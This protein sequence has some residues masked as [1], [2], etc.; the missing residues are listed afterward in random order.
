MLSHDGEV[1]SR[2]SAGAPRCALPGVVDYPPVYGMI[3]NS[4]TGTGNSGKSVFTID[5][6][7]G[8]ASAGR[9]ADVRPIDPYIIKKRRSSAFQRGIAHGQQTSFTVTLTPGVRENGCPNS[10]CTH[11]PVQYSTENQYITRTVLCSCPPFTA[12][13]FFIL[14][15][16]NHTS[17]ESARS[18]HYNGVWYVFSRAHSAPISSCTVHSQMTVTRGV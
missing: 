15:L 5:C 14:T 11:I 8:T 9:A 2:P 10:T 18:Q 1:S 4:N 13:P 3:G 7:R 12:H 16:H 17:I 6:A